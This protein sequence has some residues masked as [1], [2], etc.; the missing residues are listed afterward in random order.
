MEPS[1]TTK[2]EP[3]QICYEPVEYFAILDCGH[4]HFCWQC[5]MKQRLK[6]ENVACPYCKHQSVNVYICVTDD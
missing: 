5:I 3:C 2:G 4:S 1:S 6:L